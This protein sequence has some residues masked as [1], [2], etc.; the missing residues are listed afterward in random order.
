MQDNPFK[1][2]GVRED[3]TQAE[4]FDAY[5]KLRDKYAEER[6]FEGE[7][8]AEAARK[9]SEVQYAYEQAIAS[10][11]RSGVVDDDRGGSAAFAEVRRLIRE[12]KIADAQAR[13][14]DYM[15]RPAEWH[16]LQA[17]IYHQKNWFSECK[18]QLEMAVQMEPDNTKYKE[19]LE[20]LKKEMSGNF[21]FG[22][23]TSEP[24]PS[25]GSAPTGRSYRR[26]DAGDCCD[27]CS[28]VICAD[29]CCECCGS[30]LISCC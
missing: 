19:T 2:L 25:G 17:K 29:C 13:L 7:A 26:S 20:R 16:Y 11:T 18:K 6:F 30:D 21:A 5:C 12:G 24:R 23:R 1:I 10:K 14:D 28:A 4:I 22:E 9:L 27:C 3:A 15:D 8:G